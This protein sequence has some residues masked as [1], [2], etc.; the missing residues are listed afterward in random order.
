VQKNISAITQKVLFI[1]TWEFSNCKN[2]WTLIT[3]ERSIA[4]TK[5]QTY[6]YSMRWTAGRSRYTKSDMVR[7]TV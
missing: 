5:T 4:L 2:Y 7:Q 3:S 6:Y 1:Q